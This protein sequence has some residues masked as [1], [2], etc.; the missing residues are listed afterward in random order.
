MTNV[1]TGFDQEY[2]NKGAILVRFVLDDSSFCFLNNHLAAGEEN[3]ERRR[4]DIVDIL[5]GATFKPCSAATKRAYSTRG[6]GTRVSD[7]SHIFFA[8]ESR[9]PSNPRRKLTSPWPTGDLNFRVTLPR[10][11]VIKAAAEN[12]LAELI[13]YDELGLEMRYNP[14]FRLHSYSEQP[15]TFP[16]T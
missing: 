14:S 5:D 7:H 11:A 15:L 6:D 1:K 13:P 9:R 3:A 4:K 16:P 8:G 12:K 10:K 2:G